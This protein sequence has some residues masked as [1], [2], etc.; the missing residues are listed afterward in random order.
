[1][2]KKGDL[3]ECFSFVSY[4]TGVDRRKF[5]CYLKDELLNDLEHLIRLARHIIIDGLILY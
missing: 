2:T 5:K 4:G 1:M 3:S